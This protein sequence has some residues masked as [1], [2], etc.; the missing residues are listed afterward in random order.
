MRRR[1]VT[2]PPPKT[3]TKG[4]PPVFGTADPRNPSNRTVSID[5]TAL[6]G[7]ASVA[8]GAR[9]RILSGLYAG[10]IATVEA[11]AGGVIPAAVVRTETGRT[12]R[13]RTIDLEPIRS[14]D[15]GPGAPVDPGAT[16]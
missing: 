7:R 2:Y 1:K 6:A 9:V 5:L 13:A 12:R 14:D 15:P 10:E 3:A 8:P 11:M 16:A 4:P